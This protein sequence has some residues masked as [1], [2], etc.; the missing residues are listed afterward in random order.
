MLIAAIPWAVPVSAFP[1]SQGGTKELTFFFHYASS[2]ESLGGVSTNYLADTAANFQNIKNHDTKATGQPK[3]QVDFY[4]FPDL[5]GPVRLSGNWEVVV[6]ANSTALHPATWNLEFWEKTPSGSIVW[7]SGALNPSVLGGPSA[8]NGYVDAP[9]YGYTLTASN[10][11]R[12]LASGDTL[13]VEITVNTGATVPLSLW[14]DSAQQPSRMVL[15]SL[16]YMRISGIST[17]DANETLR[18]VFFTFW[19]SSQRN[20]TVRTVLTDP[21]GGYDIHQVLVSVKDPTGAWVVSNATMP[22]ASGTPFSFDSAYSYSLA[23]ASN[24]PK[25]NYTVF[26]MALDNNAENQFAHTG[27]YFPFAAVASTQFSIGLQYPVHVRVFDTH[28]SPLVGAKVGF[29]SG[30]VEY[31]AGYTGHDG[32]YNVTLFT[33]E[34]VAEVWWEGVPVLSQNVSVRGAASINLTAAVYYPTFKIVDDLQNPLGGAL[35]FLHFPN[36]SASELPSTTD[37]RGTFTL[38]QEP[39]GN[40]TALVLFEGIEVADSTVRVASDGPFVIPTMVFQLRV[41]V[42]DS[43]GGPLNGST[44]L[45][46]SP[47]KANGGAY[48]Y[49]VTNKAGEANFSLPVGNYVVTAEYHAVYLLSADSNR[50]AVAVTL[51]HDTSLVIKMA[52]LPPPIWL[53][54]GFQLVVVALLVL[55]GV[56][57]FVLMRRRRTQGRP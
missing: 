8:N 51:S 49:L 15:P 44:V 50:T 4:L 6:F 39:K 42:E 1:P 2:A 40:Y 18:T 37:A 45:V 10:L 31:A 24:A 9:I 19:P 22:K 53:T 32:T 55:A 46:A 16:D 17:A 48:G 34:F 41:T 14:Y 35:V 3:L 29:F 57:V 20:V 5:A 26:V 28:S 36:G 33:G 21:F 43:G 30:E 25:G 13:E 11:N 7:D 52:N 47:G 12:T 56:S 23:Y 54:L 38:S 27:T